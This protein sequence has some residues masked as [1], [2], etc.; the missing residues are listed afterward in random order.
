MRRLLACLIYLTTASLTLANPL[1]TR[2]LLTPKADLI[3]TPF[4]SPDSLRFLSASILSVDQ[5]VNPIG[6]GETYFDLVTG[7]SAFPQDSLPASPPIVGY[8]P[9]SGRYLTLDRDLNLWVHDP[10]Q[11]PRMIGLTLSQASANLLSDGQHVFVSSD[12]TFGRPSTPT[13]LYSIEDE[14]IVWEKNGSYSLSEDESRAIEVLEIDGFRQQQDG[15]IASIKIISTS[16]GDLLSEIDLTQTYPENTYNLAAAAPN[17]KGVILSKAPSFTQ[18]SPTDSSPRF[19]FLDTPTQSAVPINAATSEPIVPPPVFSP[20]G[21]YFYIWETLN[22]NIEIFSSATRER[23]FSR[24]VSNLLARFA[25]NSSR[26]YIAQGQG[27]QV[28]AYT[29]P[30]GQLEE[31]YTLPNESETLSAFSV[32]PDGKFVLAAS[33]ES[34]HLLNTQTDDSNELV[35]APSS[36]RTATFSPD[37]SYCLLFSP[38]GELISVST[39][40]TSISH[41]IASPSAETLIGPPVDGELSYISRFFRLVRKQL[42]SGEQTHTNLL[43]DGVNSARFIANAGDYMLVEL[44][45]RLESGFQQS[46]HLIDPT[47]L[48]SLWEPPIGSITLQTAQ[49][50]EQAQTLAV[51]EKETFSNP[52]DADN[53]LLAYRRNNDTPILNL[54]SGDFPFLDLAL[55]AQ[56]TFL[57]ALQSG[58]PTNKVRLF[59][60]AD[61]SETELSLQT[62]DWS[63]LLFDREGNKLYLLES[64]S[65]SQISNYTIAVVN[66]SGDPTYEYI[67]LRGYPPIAILDISPDGRFLAALAQRKQLVLIDLK[68]QSVTAQAETD[69]YPNNVYFSNFGPT[70]EQAYFSSDSRNLLFKTTN[71]SIRR[72]NIDPLELVAPKLLPS[73]NGLT[74]NYQSEP[75]DI[76]LLETSL[77]LKSWETETTKHPSSTSLSLPIPAPPLSTP[78]FYRLW[79]SEA[80]Q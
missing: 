10:N 24:T 27:S 77:D 26:L 74:F 58:S 18:P 48:E 66:V 39:E 80:D 21:A 44:T 70:Q 17:L 23:L 46:I 2:S 34:L 40:N 71:G 54:Q 9:A 62:G 42:T 65:T 63:K 52:F 13:L 32:S 72:W 14:K 28:N 35:L 61:G 37:S 41:R 1:P 11:E 75:G 67:N 22:Q 60:I 29:L 79:K 45:T 38:I 59:S 12:V 64:N 53:R 3:A 30:S 57:A 5:S 15:G 36:F 50:D 7:E 68:S 76:F 19:L 8:H 43:L 49:M 55:N 20:D 6:Y 16:T 69:W 31:T 47:R 78:R 51:I 4:V 73:P 33:R 25:S 56:G